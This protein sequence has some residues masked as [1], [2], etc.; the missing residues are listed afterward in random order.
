MLHPKGLFTA[1][2]KDSVSI[3]LGLNSNLSNSSLGSLEDIVMGAYK[4]YKNSKTTKEI[5][6]EIKYGSGGKFSPIAMDKKYK[7]SVSFSSISSVM[8]FDFS[9]AIKETREYDGDVVWYRTNGKD[10]DG[11]WVKDTM[12]RR[13]GVRDYGEKL[14]KYT[15]SAYDSLINARDKIKSLSDFL[16]DFILKDE[17]E[18]S[19]LLVN[20]NKLL[21]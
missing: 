8:G 7:L 1:N 21:Q 6:I 17:H 9:V 4:L 5:Y 20:G 15:D 13:S 18:M 12:F 16:Y 14:I 19:I 11:V 2:L 3:P 10:K